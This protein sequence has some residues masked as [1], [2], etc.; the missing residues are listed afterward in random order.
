MRVL[1]IKTSSLGDIIHTLPALSDALKAIP[2]IQFD[3]LVEDSLQTIPSWHKGVNHII[4]MPFRRLRKKGL[5]TFLMILVQGE[6]SHFIKKLQA[7]KYDVIIDA[8]GLFKSIFWLFFL[9][10]K[11]V[12]FSFSSIKEPLA[13]I[14][15]Q[16]K[17]KVSWNLHAVVRN[18]SLFAESLNYPLPNNVAD[19]GIHLPNVSN[20]NIS[21][22]E[23]TSYV[24]FL[25]GTTWETKLWP[26][27]YW[28]KL[29]KM[30]EEH[31]MKIKLFWGD[32]IE[33]QRAH[34]IAQH[35]RNAEVLPRASLEEAA[36]I[37]SRAKVV[38]AL[39]TGLGH[40]AC[41]LNVPTISL[42]GPTDPALTGTLGLNQIHLKSLFSCAPCL[43]KNCNYKGER[44]VNPP[45]F[46]LIT[47]E[48]VWKKI[49]ENTEGVNIT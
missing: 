48:L 41:A 25:H 44:L 12:G 39:D 19:Y 1:I 15:Y 38:V 11:K 31:K 26:T 27:Q 37:L 2:N 43:K 10:G 33:E 7:N 5:F 20:N 14:F 23:S 30:I 18:R 34:E 3:W 9:K 17:I 21:D 22:K 49:R 6:F 29:G 45:C 42:Y 35:L 36:S 47:P 40:L 13:S 16:K 28:I 46:G 8:Q 32:E 4:P 24:V